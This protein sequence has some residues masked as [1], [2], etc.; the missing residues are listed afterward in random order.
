MNSRSD[1]T[2]CQ[3]RD[4]FQQVLTKILGSQ[5]NSICIPMHDSSEKELS[6]FQIRFKLGRHLVRKN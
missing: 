5:F 2:F 1:K 3:I 4:L 6:D